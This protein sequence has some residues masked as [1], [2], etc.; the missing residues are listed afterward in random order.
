MSLYM[1]IDA[2]GTKTECAIGNG[3]VL[4]GEATGESCKVAQVGEE[5]ARRTLQE[6]I[7]RTCK[8]A[9]A[10]PNDI[11][12]LCIGISGASV[13]GNAAWVQNV[14]QEVLTCKV[15][16]MGDHIVAHRRGPKLIA[17]LV[18]ERT[19]AHAAGR[20]V[21]D[22]ADADLGRRSKRGQRAAPGGRLARGSRMPPQ[23]AA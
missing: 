10:S 18:E 9:N 17:G 16:V 11:E 21:E 19:P 20:R 23:H 4:L 13:P 8:A 2:G 22:L 5:Q 14:I 15:R 6:I 3:T 7:R 1:G 12:Q